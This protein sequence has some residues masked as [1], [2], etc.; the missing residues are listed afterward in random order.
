MNATALPALPA[1]FVGEAIVDPDAVAGWAG[2][3]GPFWQVPTA[4]VVPRTADDVGLLILWARTH[5]VAIIPRGAGTGMP[6]GNVGPGVVLDLSDLD[7]VVPDDPQGYAVRAGAGATGDA[8]REIA[9]AHGRQLPALPSSAPWSTVG[10][11]VACNAAGARSYALGSIRDWVREI[12]VVRADGVVDVH[13]RGGG[14]D[15]EPWAGLRSRLKAD[16]PQPLPWPRV[17][18]NSSGYA[19]D[20]FLDTGDVLDLLVGSEGTLGVVTE[21]VLETHAPPA[22]RAVV[23]LG[24]PDRR[25]LPELVAGLR[26][27]PHMRACEYLGS[28]LI[29]LGGLDH[30]PRLRGVRT[31]EGL[32]LVELA[33]A[34][35]AV[36]AR[37]AELTREAP[38]GAVAASDPA[39]IESLW[40]LRHAANPMLGRALQQGRRSTQ[41]IEDCVVPVERLP[42]FLSGLE[43][44]LA[45][46]RTEAV[47]FGHAG[48]GN[49]HVNPL[50]DLRRP[51]WRRGV[52]GILDETVSLVAGLGGTLAG[53]HGDGR[54]RTPFLD[55]I[56][57]PE[58]VEAFATVKRAL[59]PR[60]ILNPGVVV[61]VAGVSPLEG[62]GA[63]PD[64]ASGSQ[65]PERT[66]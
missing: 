63:A 18:K 26:S 16:L 50:I 12:T 8:C 36:E 65:G 21:V 15:T 45:R 10:G 59:D 28:L 51:D 1:G 5:G 7:R 56:F 23:A 31:S 24:V 66:R 3:S 4:V 53:E 13:R 64:F 46:Y 14:S 9:L 42:E 47:I 33:G 60:G 62:L 43:E 2:A 32:L 6:G 40:T 37:A 57:S 58:V 52:A 49:L 44:I 11:M 27:D 30:D 34:R 54:L 55:R 35:E 25:A 19:L 39:G 22:H 48:E 41:F 20:R 29:R 61:P 38:W 17:R